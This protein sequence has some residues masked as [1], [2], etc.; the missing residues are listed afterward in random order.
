MKSSI[1]GTSKLSTTKDNFVASTAESRTPLREDNRPM[2]MS[3]LEKNVYS[4][5]V[6]SPPSLQNSSI[7]LEKL[8]KRLEENGFGSLHASLKGQLS[9]T[10][11]LHL[12]STLSL[13]V[14]EFE[15]RGNTIQN[16]VNELSHGKEVDILLIFN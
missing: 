5:Q 10:Q 16:L 7:Q 9:E 15:N 3:D 6:D 11:R 4:S 8:S 2:H 14:S 1:I 13:L 12:I